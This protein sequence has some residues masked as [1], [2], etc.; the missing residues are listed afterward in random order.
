MK[1]NEGPVLATVIPVY[2]EAAF[3]RE[4]VM[5][6][7]NQTLP[8]SQHIILI[9]DGGSSDGTTDIIQDLLESYQGEEYPQIIALDNP[10]KSVAHA[11]NLAMN[12]LPDTIEYLVEFIGHAKVGQAHLQQRLDAWD[13]CAR[14]Y[15]DQ[16]AAVGVKVVPS[17]NTPTI[18]GGWIE[19][20]LGSA[21][22]QSGGQFAQFSTISL[23]NI[24]A[25]VTHRRKAIEA[26]GG[27]DPRFISSQDSELSMRLKDAGYILCRHPSTYVDMRKRDRLSQWWKMGHRYGFWRTKLILK[28]PGRANWK[29]FLPWFGV[30][31]TA[32]LFLIGNSHWLWLPIAYGVSLFSAG[33]ASFW[34]KRAVTHVLGVPLCL[35]LLHTSFSLG[36]V[37]GLIRRGKFSTDRN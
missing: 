34:R 22:G 29:E 30:I 37:D 23:T 16:L 5:S 35:F 3:L 7:V 19:S 11:R 6:L 21:L 24:P 15:G 26:V 2:N 32:S 17:S 33:I 4:C 10:Q 36:L 27:W 31:L 25:F 1:G 28:Y 18:V 12:H 14:I 9:V 13:E 20:A 8:P